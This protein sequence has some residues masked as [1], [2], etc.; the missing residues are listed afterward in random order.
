MDFLLEIG[1]EEI[2]P[3]WIEP[4][5]E[6]LKEKARSLLLNERLYP[7]S[8]KAYGTPRRLALVINGLSERQEDIENEIIGPPALVSP[9]GFAKVH[10]VSEKDLFIKEIKGKR[11]FC[12]IK[13]EKGEETEKVLKRILFDMIKEIKFPKH[14]RWKTSFTFARPIRWIVALLDNKT[15][16][17]ECE[18]FVVSNKTYGLRTKKEPIVIPSPSSY[19]STLRENNIIVDPKERKLLILKMFKR[20]AD[21]LKAKPY[22]KGGLLDEIANLVEMPVV[23]RCGY[24]RKFLSLPADVLTTALIHHQRYVPLIKGGS[25]IP[26]FLVVSNGGE[27]AKDIIRKGHERVISARLY[28]ALFFFKEDLKLPLERFSE[29]LKGIIFHK[30]LGSLYDKTMRNVWLSTSLALRLMDKRDIPNVSKASFLC[31]LDL[32]THMVQ[33]FP[34]LQGIMGYHYGIKQGISKKIAIVSAEHYSILPKSLLGRIVNLAD[35]MDTLVGYFNIGLIPKGSEDPYALRRCGNA[36]VKIILSSH[37]KQRISL[38]SFIREACRG[39]KTI[40]NENK[41]VEEVLLFIRQRF[42]FILKER[43]PP[44]V[45]EAVLNTGFDDLV[46]AKE[47]IEALSSFFIKD[48]KFNDLI[49][50]FKRVIN[51]L[52]G[53]APQGFNKDLLKEDAE[54]GLYLSL[55]KTKEALEDAISKTDYKNAFSLFASLKPQIDLFFDEVMVM[56][57]DKNLQENRLSLLFFIKELFRRLADISVLT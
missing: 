25:L 46:D 19:V 38:S 22:L 4:A 53:K 13:K 43:Y 45:I 35:R 18:D 8:I 42:E 37:F 21:K 11:Y 32:A 47:R 31:K 10:N 23:I 48:P 54:K 50:L 56:V 15:I 52:K 34:E 3:S 41:I 33:E 30:G 29:R 28:D 16:D 1:C 5:L 14:M 57:P 55:L 24:K 51:I 40:E 7:S 17:F 12:F 6:Q 26:Y 36:I 27:K 2:P 20:E 49:T 44:R 39:F 9:S